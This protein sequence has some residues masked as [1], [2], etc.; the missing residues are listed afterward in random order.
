[1]LGRGE[2]LVRVVAGG[3]A[4]PALARLEALALDHLLDVADCFLFPAH[5]RR[6]HVNRP[7]ILQRKT[8]TVIEE[9][10]S[11]ARNAG[12]AL[13]VALLADGLP[14]RGFEVVRVDDGVV[15]APFGQ[16]V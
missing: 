10:T 5:R 4:E 9:P 14:Q 1:M 2:G 8:R 16:L 7:E 15:D 13:K 11:A 12:L 6:G 3:T